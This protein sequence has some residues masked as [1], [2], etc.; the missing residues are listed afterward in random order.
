MSASSS[1]SKSTKPVTAS[2]LSNYPIGV[3]PGSSLGSKGPQS[4]TDAQKLDIERRLNERLK[5]ASDAFRAQ[6]EMHMLAQMNGESRAG[7]WYAVLP[8]WQSDYEYGKVLWVNA[9]AGDST[10][11]TFFERCKIEAVL[12][13]SA[14]VYLLFKSLTSTIKD[15]KAGRVVSEERLGRQLEAEYGINPVPVAKRIEND[16]SCEDGLR[17]KNLLLDIVS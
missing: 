14:G 5:N 9:G 16:D 3:A 6:N 13:N 8:D 10:S 7:G 12:G 15:M 11:Y 2:G 4:K 1:S 17:L